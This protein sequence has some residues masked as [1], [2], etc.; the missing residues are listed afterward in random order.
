MTP[1]KLKKEG[2]SFINR[3]FNAHLRELKLCVIL[4]IQNKYINRTYS[5]QTREKVQDEE[6][7]KLTVVKT[8]VRKQKVFQKN[9]YIIN[10]STN[11]PT[12]TKLDRL[13]GLD[14]THI[15]QLDS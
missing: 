6:M 15:N 5:I 4:F 9:T 11:N 7:K 12:K 3:L 2:N 14:C 8:E 1:G 13:I 10:Q